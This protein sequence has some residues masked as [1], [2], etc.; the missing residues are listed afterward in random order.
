MLRNV[1]TTSFR[2]LP[3]ST[4]FSPLVWK[5][6]LV[7]VAARSGENPPGSTAPISVTWTKFATNP[8]S[9]PRKWIGEIM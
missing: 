6:F 4:I 5:P 8:V 2:G 9:V 1:S 7:V 3:R